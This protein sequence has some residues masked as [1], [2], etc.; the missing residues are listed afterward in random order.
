MFI[1]NLTIKNFRCFDK[2]GIEVS[3]NKGLTAFIGRNGS[4]NEKGEMYIYHSK[5]LGR[6]LLKLSFSR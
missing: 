1:K 2:N 4:E 6:A 5:G 3:F